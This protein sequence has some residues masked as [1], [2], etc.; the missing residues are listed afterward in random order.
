MGEQATYTLKVDWNNDGDFA[1]AGENISADWIKARIRRGFSGPLARMAMVGRASFQLK[2][3]AQA[4]SPPA[5]AIVLPACPV[6]FQMTYNATTETLFR[7][8]VEAIRPDFGSR[9]RRQCTLDCVDAISKLDRYEGEIALQTDVYANTIIKAVVDAVYTPP[10]ESYQSG[11]NLFATSGDRWSWEK[12]EGGPPMRGPY[13]A[14]RASDKILDACTADWGRYFIAADGTSTFANRHQMPLDT[15][16]ELALDDTMVAMDYQ[17]SAGTIY[18]YI[19]I[20]C[21]PRTIG[22]VYEVLGGLYQDDAPQIAGSAASVF[23]IRF[24]DPSNPALTI[25]GKDCVTPVAGTDYHCTDD[26]EGEGTDMDASVT[27]A[28]AFYGDW[29]ELTLTNASANPVY[30]QKLQ[31]R[32]Y[33]VRSNDPVTV[34]AQDAVT[35]IPKY[36][37]RKLALSIPLISR[38]EHA[39]MLADHLLLVYAAP[40]HEIRGVT[41]F[42]NR[43]AT[44]MAA[45]RDLELMDKVALTETQ[46]G[47]SAVATHIYGI[48]H[49]IDHQTV[50]KVSLDLETPFTYAGTPFRLDISALNSGDVLIY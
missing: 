28:A 50:H 45:A 15:T 27:C 39:Q 30:V 17:K 1:D 33:A 23:V 34:V 22:Q 40:V 47:L 11:L 46:T 20:R 5:V 7:G 18:N 44:Q 14:I 4:Y 31:V 21:F 41:F 37:K 32:G 9:L 48:E 49:M 13:E 43:N 16:I 6:I 25:G 36:G 19:E 12:R 29:A 35:S 26:V 24:R 2:N 10:A 38:P 3:S 42:A 8:F